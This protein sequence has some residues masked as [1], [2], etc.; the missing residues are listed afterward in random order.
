MADPGAHLPPTEASGAKVR[1]DK[2]LW[3][4]RFFKTRQLAVEAI[5][6]GKV[7]LNGQRAKPGKEIGIGARLEI[8]RER[9]VWEVVVEALNTQRRPAREAVLLYRETPESQARRE[10]DAA[11]RRDEKSFANEPAHRPS[12]RDRRLIHRFKQSLD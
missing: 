10:A 1:L 7:H 6:G 11:R 12:K 4:A 2:W 3:A 8:T 9:E 5:N